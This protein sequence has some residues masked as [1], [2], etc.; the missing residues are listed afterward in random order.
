MHMRSRSRRW[1]VNLLLLMCSLWLGLLVFEGLFRV[2]SGET[3]RLSGMY[4]E[5]RIAGVALTP[6]FS[7]SMRTAEF[8]YQVHVNELGIRDDAIGIKERDKSRV[9]LI[10][11]SFV[12]GVGVDL[13]DSVAKRLQHHLRALASG[14]VEVINAGVPGYSPFQE[15]AT[16]RRLAPRLQPDLVVQVVFVGDDWYGNYARTRAADSP[17]GPTAWLRKESAAFRFVDRFLISRL[18]GRSH[19]E[20]HLIAPSSSF[21]AQRADVLRILGETR[22]AAAE[23]GADYLVVLCPRFSQVYDD[24]WS[25]AKFVYRLS[26]AEYSPLE[27]NRSF[28]QLLKDSGFWHLDLLGPLR[29]EGRRRPLHFTVD[30]H[31]NRDGNDFVGSLLAAS[32]GPWF[33]DRGAF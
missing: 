17:S 33:H 8:E 16:L 4:S 30:G 21:A 10:G 29:E 20:P 9:L 15:L 24:A 12:F 5:D 18:K 1:L 6:G 26:D 2:V 14:D 25:K 22:D 32:V 3:P 23:T 19:Y 27:P 7:G 13:H 11:D 28:T 31:W